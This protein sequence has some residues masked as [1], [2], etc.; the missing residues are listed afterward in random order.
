MQNDRLLTAGTHEAPIPKVE[1]CR[2]N[3]QF[4]AMVSAGRDE[5]VVESAPGLEPLAQQ[6]H[7]WNALKEILPGNI[8]Q[9][10]LVQAGTADPRLRFN[11]VSRSVK[12]LSGA[13]IT[14]AETML[15]ID[16]AGAY[17]AEAIYRINNS[18]EQFLEIELPEGV[19]F[20]PRTSTASRSSP[21]RSPRAADD[22]S[23]RIPLVKTAAGDRD[24]K[25]VLKYGG[26][27]GSL[28]TLTQVNFP[29][30]RTDKK[31]TVEKSQVRLYLPDTYRWF[32][33]GGTMRHAESEQDMI[34][35]NVAADIKETERLLDVLRHG[36]PFAKVRATNNLK[37]LAIVLDN[38]RSMSVRDGEGSETGKVLRK[39]QETMSEVQKAI[40]EQEQAGEKGAG[41][42]DNR[43]RMNSLYAGQVNTRARNVVD[44]LGNNFDATLPPQP[45]GQKGEGQFNPLWLANSQLENPAG[46]P[47]EDNAGRKGA[48]RETKEGG[49]T[50][51]RLA[52]GRIS[53]P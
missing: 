44:D 17:R 19:G 24:Y 31:I 25:L 6:Q 9:A 38:S 35:G 51:S 50:L 32:D 2:T 20:G 5:V 48:A 29:L 52:K 23:V 18:T 46:L 8:T 7:E 39:E 27:T 42:Q 4:V 53:A 13:R 14:L 3:R 45:Q 11:T 21:R 33:F 22:R 12:D 26:R 1:T 37:Q 16:P 47:G 41:E 34:A 43:F 15:A 40:Q 28:G 49:Q 30:L 36:D 10:Y